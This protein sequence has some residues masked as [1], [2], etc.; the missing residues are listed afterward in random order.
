LFVEEAT[1]QQYDIDSN[2]ETSCLVVWCP[3]GSLETVDGHE[4][5]AL[6]FGDA[7]LECFE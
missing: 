1:G 2:E 6:M 4:V 3:D 5:D 7:G